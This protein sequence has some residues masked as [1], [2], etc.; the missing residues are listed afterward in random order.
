[1]GP[2]QSTGGQQ[3]VRFEAQRWA[4]AYTARPSRRC[5]ERPAWLTTK[6]G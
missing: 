5:R 4:P 2:N 6:P 3:A 1:M